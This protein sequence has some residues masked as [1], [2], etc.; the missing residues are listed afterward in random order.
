[1]LS[2]ASCLLVAQTVDRIAI[3]PGMTEMEA[4]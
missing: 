4:A 3:L 2:L 1:M